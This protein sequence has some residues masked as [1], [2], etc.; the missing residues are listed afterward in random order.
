MFDQ[1]LAN[2]DLIVC[3]QPRQSLPVAKTSQFCQAA[4]VDRGTAQQRDTTAGLAADYLHQ[5][6]PPK[7]QAEGVVVM[8]CETC[9]AITSVCHIINTVNASLYLH[10]ARLSCMPCSICHGC[11]CRAYPLY[12]AIHKHNVTIKI[13]P[14]ILHNNT[15]THNCWV[16]LNLS[17]NEL[18]YCSEQASS[19]TDNGTTP[20]TCGSGFR[21]SP[22]QKD[23][24]SQ[25]AA[26]SVQGTC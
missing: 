21:P 10:T 16:S 25:S 11:I 18:R 22:M 15:T 1:G 17:L 5:L 7:L 12:S 26:L 3:L 19:T 23:T 14:D 2:I 13:Q 4:C 24:A 8:C 20:N 9:T 6:V